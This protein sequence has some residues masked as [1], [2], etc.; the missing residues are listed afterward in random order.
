MTIDW[1][2]L[3]FQTVNVAVLVWLLQRFFWRPVSAMIEQRRDVTKH[4]L[5]EA[6]ATRAKAAAD[7]AGIETTRAG[8]AAERDAILA[9]AHDAAGKASADAAAE[10]A[11]AAATLE[12]T[13]RATMEKE[14]QAAEQAW[15]ER[16]ARLAID[17]SGRL[18]AR[19]DG[20]AVRAAFLDGLVR[21]IAAMPEAARRAATADGAPLEAFSAAALDPAERERANTLIVEALGGHPAIL[22]K[23]DPALIAGLELHGPHFVTSN[24]WRADLARILAS[25]A[26]IPGVASPSVASPGRHDPSPADGSV[27]AAW[28]NATRNAAAREGRDDA[29]AGEARLDAVGATHEK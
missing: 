25:F 20:A 12:A 3:G 27:P 7:L 1:W 16:S 24:S 5:A 6:E 10:A 23:T 19:L 28:D 26:T 11:K 9:A 15:T 18:T 4:A 21:E 13:A 22:F 2:T 29:E 8:F 14:R 17:I